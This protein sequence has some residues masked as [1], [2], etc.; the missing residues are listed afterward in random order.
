MNIQS[1]VSLLK[2]YEVAKGVREKVIAYQRDVFE[3]LANE[4]PSL[5]G[6][7]KVDLCGYCAI[8]SRVLCYE[9]LEAGFDSPFI[10]FCKNLII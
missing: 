4:L 10:P 6:D 3:Q 2:I 7:Y 5:A 9:L 1:E 8:A